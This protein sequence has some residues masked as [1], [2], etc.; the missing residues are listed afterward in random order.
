MRISAEHILLIRDNASQ[1]S[2][3]AP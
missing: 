3:K 2:Q 1:Q